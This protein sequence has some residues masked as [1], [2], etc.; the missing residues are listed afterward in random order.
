MLPLGPEFQKHINGYLELASRATHCALCNLVRKG[1]Q[2]EFLATSAAVLDQYDADQLD[3]E[4]SR[5]VV[6]NHPFVSGVPGWVA[7]RGRKDSVACID[8]YVSPRAF[9]VLKVSPDSGKLL[10]WL[11]IEGNQD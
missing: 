4:I 6:F 5:S 1:L 2:R 3:R 11:K 9:C 10:L 8:V 7:L